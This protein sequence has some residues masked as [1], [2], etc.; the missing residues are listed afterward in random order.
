MTVLR[1]NGHNQSSLRS[2]GQSYDWLLRFLSAGD[3][4]LKTAPWKIRIS[5]SKVKNMVLNECLITAHRILGG[6]AY[7]A[8]QLSQQ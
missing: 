1:I 7:F 5:T 2:S 3:V 4:P 8:V 6:I